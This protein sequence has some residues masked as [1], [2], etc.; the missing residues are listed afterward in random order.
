MISSPMKILRQTELDLFVQLFPAIYATT[1]INADAADVTKTTIEAIDTAMAG[2]E[3]AGIVKD[4]AAQVAKLTV[5]PPN[6]FKEL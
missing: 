3:A 1:G 6:K 2:L 4:T 5:K